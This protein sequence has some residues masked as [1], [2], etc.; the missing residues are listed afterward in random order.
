VKE[1][2]LRR[3]MSKERQK[4]TFQCCTE[5]TRKTRREVKGNRQ[6]GRKKRRPEL[7]KDEPYVVDLKVKRCAEGTPK[8]SVT[9]STV[10]L[11]LAGS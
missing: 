6:R 9:I 2:R 1:R 3:K 11:H 5:R 8:I 10:E 4:M 7:K